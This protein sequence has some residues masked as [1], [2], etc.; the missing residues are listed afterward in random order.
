[1]QRCSSIVG[2]FRSSVNR[3]LQKYTFGTTRLSLVG[4]P[5]LGVFDAVGWHPVIDIFINTLFVD[6]QCFSQLNRCDDAKSCNRHSGRNECRRLSRSRRAKLKHW[7]SCRGCSCACS[8]SSN[9]ENG[10]C[11]NRLIKRLFASIICRRLEI[12]GLWRLGKSWFRV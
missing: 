8:S 9:S 7:R 2:D 4:Q 12:L 10:R 11:G 1:M 6:A 3:S 5:F